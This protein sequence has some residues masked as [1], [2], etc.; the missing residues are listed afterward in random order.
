[1]LADLSL[2]LPDVIT[3]QAW[4][5]FL[6]HLEAGEAITLLD[7][8]RGQV[9]NFR[10]NQRK[11]HRA[12]LNAMEAW[13]DNAGF[14]F[15]YSR[16]QRRA[17]E[18]WRENWTATHDNDEEQAADTPLLL[19]M[20][21][22]LQDGVALGRREL[23]HNRELILLNQ[24]LTHEAKRSQ[25]Q[26]EIESTQARLD[27]RLASSNRSNRAVA[28]TRIASVLAVA[29]KGWLGGVVQMMRQGLIEARLSA[30]RAVAVA[31]ECRCQGAAMQRLRAAIALQ[32]HGM[33]GLA[34]AV[35]RGSQEEE[36]VLRRQRVLAASRS[37]VRR[38][39]EIRM[40]QG[41]S[42]ACLLR[43][44]LHASRATRAIE[45]QRVITVQLS[46]TRCSL[47]RQR[48]ALR[49]T[50]AAGMHCMAAVGSRMA[51]GKE[52]AVMMEFRSGFHRAQAKFSLDNL[53]AEMKARANAASFRQLSA[54]LARR[55]RGE[56]GMRLHAWRGWTLNAH[57]EG[58]K[59]TQALLIDELSATKLESAVKR[60]SV[61]IAGVMRGKPGALLQSWRV[62]CEASRR[63][64]GVDALRQTLQ[65]HANS[66][67][68]RAGVSVLRAV[69]S[70][71]H[72]S[73]CSCLVE[74]QHRLE[75]HKAATRHDGR[76]EARR[77][78]GR[79]AAGVQQ[80]FF[81]FAGHWSRSLLQGKALHHMAQAHT[82]EC[83]IQRE[84][85]LSARLGS[86]HQIALHG[87][88]RAQSERLRHRV[89]DSLYTG[90]QRRAARV[91]TQSQ[92]LRL[93]RVVLASFLIDTRRR[94]LYML[95]SGM[96]ASLQESTAML[97][98]EKARQQGCVEKQKSLVQ[99]SKSRNEQL[100]TAAATKH[101]E[102][103]ELRKAV[104]RLTA[105]CSVAEEDAAETQQELSIAEARSRRHEEACDEQRLSIQEHL[106]LLQE[107]HDVC[108]EQGSR[109]C[110]RDRF[111]LT[112]QETITELNEAMRCKENVR[113]IS[114]QTIAVAT[115]TPPVPVLAHHLGQAPCQES[116]GA[117]TQ[118]SYIFGSN[119]KRDDETRRMQRDNAGRE[120]AS[121]T[122][123]RAALAPHPQKATH[124]AVKR[125]V[126]ATLRCVGA[127]LDAMEKATEG[128][129]RQRKMDRY[130]S[131]WQRNLDLEPLP[132]HT[133]TTPPPPSAARGR[134]RSKESIALKLGGVKESLDVMEGK[135]AQFAAARTG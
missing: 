97:E 93:L 110:E 70:S 134:R 18:A 126:K 41:L 57:A 65:K 118:A 60:M 128:M 104:K 9:Y 26:R 45:A 7:C 112:Q 91:A 80:L 69:W 62:E 29:T 58:G 131:Q 28:V 111:I 102:M 5:S 85:C 30:I 40:L 17:L 124:R 108:Q 103:A 68:R 51:R 89:V 12:S 20:L 47:A 3:A 27:A 77:I 123:A 59:A 64:S 81:S 132:G 24:Q 116:T 63:A 55:M 99:E 114:Q 53:K 13:L 36:K 75:A 98:R 115:T 105:A 16:A 88:E 48:E 86:L 25:N 71:F 43:W 32:V 50:M 76:Y 109:L 101:A 67:M 125:R 92:S 82:S 84:E 129:E 37:T 90:W 121:E 46:H 87:V 61:V 8:L 21:V 38:S 6:E 95:Q 56:L 74:W 1:M 54:V 120:T 10:S 119:P 133:G 49:L 94:F 78:A 107:L 11:M 22:L 135:M 72:A 19:P 113:H 127:N 2:L 66:K 34:V 106:G 79:R 15:E 73:T 44:Q 31:L 130:R 122:Q 35:W 83:A 33:L 96:A 100:E 117:G 14:A 39:M 4:I 23:S 52:R 42:T